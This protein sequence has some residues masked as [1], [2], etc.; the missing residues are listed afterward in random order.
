[1]FEQ[2]MRRAP[3]SSERASSTSCPVRPPSGLRPGLRP[4]LRPSLRFSRCSTPSPTRRLLPFLLGLGLDPPASASG[5]KM[6]VFSRRLLAWAMG[7]VLQ[8]GLLLQ[9]GLCY[10]ECL[11]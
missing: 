8:L 7:L 5:M 10:V 6:A 1:M 2:A 9:L 4:S 3:L 11:L